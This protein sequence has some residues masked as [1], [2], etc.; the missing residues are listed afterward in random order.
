[1]TARLRYL[2]DYSVTNPFQTMLYERASRHGVEASPINL[3][4][5]ADLDPRHDP[6]ASILHL[7]WTNPIVQAHRDPADARRSLHHAMH[8]LERV[9]TLGG[10][11]VWT[12]HNALPHD[13]RH[14]TLEVELCRFLADRAEVTHLLTPT[15][16]AATAPYYLLDGARSITVGHASYLGAYRDDIT[17]DDARTRLGLQPDD[18]VVV[19][20]GALRAYRGIARLVEAATHL[21]R[22]RPRL[23]LLIAGR[24]AR[25]FDVGALQSRL[26]DLDGAVL[27]SGFVERD[28]VQVWMRAADVAVMPYELVLNSASFPLALTFGLPVVAPALGVFLD[29]QREPVVH[30][31][32]ARSTA[33]LV[34]ALDAALSADDLAARS[35]AAS[36]AADRFTGAEMSDEFFAQLLSRLGLS[37]AAD[38]ET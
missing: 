18:E 9:C 12:V 32:P 20:L 8:H 29:H 17:R 10:R 4:A 15:T 14:H 13:R 24:P 1:M 27:H 3:D 31:Y 26:D 19:A 11:L 25:D 37:S 5:L 36:A 35:R 16:F 7:H 28:D 22:T 38:A 30:L 23:R 6:G 34:E 33:G 21:Q 2:P